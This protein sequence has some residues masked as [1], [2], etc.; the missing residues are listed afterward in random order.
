M[1]GE[2]KQAARELMKE[3]QLSSQRLQEQEK[4]HPPAG[5]LPSPTSPPIKS[6]SLVSP[7]ASTSGPASSKSPSPSV[8]S[9]GLLHAKAM[10]LGGNDLETE[11][12]DSGSSASASKDGRGERKSSMSE[13]EEQREEQR[14]P[15]QN[16]R[17]E[18]PPDSAKTISNG[19]TSPGDVR[20]M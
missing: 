5:S 20:F 4:P 12:S 7:S 17:P 2:A 1:F 16:G 6:P 14:V 15:V 11:V 19:Y 18:P 13:L 8:T 10:P 3:R 9:P